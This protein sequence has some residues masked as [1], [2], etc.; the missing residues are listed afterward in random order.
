M[1]CPVYRY[2]EAEIE[3]EV[4]KLR[5]R[6]LQEGFQTAMADPSS[7]NTHQVAAASE[8]KNEKFRAAF[9]ISADYVSGSAFDETQKA[10]KAEEAAAKKQEMEEK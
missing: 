9:G 10:L 6:L 1:V 3:H 2:S 7:W 5:G 8:K 4:E